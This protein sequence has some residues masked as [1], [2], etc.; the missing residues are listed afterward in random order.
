MD[1]RIFTKFHLEPSPIRV[2]FD[3][4]NEA[5]EKL[6]SDQKIFQSPMVLSEKARQRLEQISPLLNSSQDFNQKL[7]IINYHDYYEKNHLLLSDGS[8]F[9]YS[10]IS[11]FNSIY[12]KKRLK[13]IK[14]IFNTKVREFQL[15]KSKSA[16]S[17]MTSDTNVTNSVITPKK[18]TIRR[19]IEPIDFNKRPLNV[20]LFGIIH[21]MDE[22]KEESFEIEKKIKQMNRN[23]SQDNIMEIN[24]TNRKKIV[25]NLSLPSLKGSSRK[26]VIKIQ[27][28]KQRHK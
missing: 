23:Y 3:R 20:K 10:M 18:K 21:K 16:L 27:K 15:S 1:Q 5:K 28:L 4:E 17:Y 6:V 13:K 24:C 7:N 26:K 8:D 22:Q 12:H 14:P 9:M 2:Y 19:I 25:S 11:K